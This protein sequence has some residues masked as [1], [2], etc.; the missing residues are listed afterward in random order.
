MEEALGVPGIFLGIWSTGD[1]IPSLAYQ[2]GR[3]GA[4]RNR[5][6]EWEGNSNCRGT[7]IPSQELRFLLSQNPHSSSS[8]VWQAIRQKEMVI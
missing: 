6:G 5:L 4:D 1:S 2:A 7:A 3:L 8:R